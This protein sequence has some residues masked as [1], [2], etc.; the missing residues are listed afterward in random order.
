MIQKRCFLL[1]VLLSLVSFAYAQSQLFGNVSNSSGEKLAGATV[2]VKNKGGY[3]QQYTSTSTTGTFKLVIVDSV[4]RNQPTLDVSLL[5][6]KKYSQVIT[7]GRTSYNVVLEESATLLEEVKV[8]LKGIISIGDTLRYDVSSFATEEDRSIGD[9]IRRLPGVTVS[10]DG[11]IFFNS[12]SISNLFI[13]GDDLMDGRYGLA[14]KAITK[15][16]IKSIDV[17][18]NHQPIKVL[19]DRVPS[20]DVAMNLVL[21]DENS[22]KLSGQADIGYG[23]IDLLDMGLTPILLN[24]KIKTLSSLKYNNLGKDYAVELSQLG[25]PISGGNESLGGL[26]SILSKPGAISLDVP[27]Q[28]YYFNNSGIFNTNNLY[29]FQ[30][31]GWQLKSNIQLHLDKN[32]VD[33]EKKSRMFTKDDVIDYDEHYDLENKPLNFQS[34]ISLTANKSTYFLEN[35]LTYNYSNFKSFNNLLFNS[36]SIGSD[37]Q[38]RRNEFVNNF[39]YIPQLKSKDVL[40]I[41]WTAGY[42][43]SPQSLQ[44][45]TGVNVDFFNKGMPY[46]KLLQNAQIPSYNNQISIGLRKKNASEVWRQNYELE[47]YNEIKDFESVITLLPTLYS[48]LQQYTGDYGNEL[49]WR[50][51]KIQ[52]NPNYSFIKNGWTINLALPIVFRSVKFRQDEYNLNESIN[53]FFLIPNI[54][55]RYKLNAEDEMSLRYNR[56]NTIGNLANVYRG[57]FIKD[58]RSISKSQASLFQRTV[59]SLGLNYNFER[60]IE[61]FFARLSASYQQVNNNATISD[62]F[63]ENLEETVFLGEKNIQKNWLYDFSVGKYIFPLA[64]NLNFKASYMFGQSEQYINQIKVPLEN[65]NLNFTTTM[66]TKP[67]DA[68][69]LDFTAGWGRFWSLSRGNDLGFDMNNDVRNLNLTA[70]SG[71][72]FIKNTLINSKVYYVHTSGQTGSN[73]STFL[74]ANVRYTIKKW[75]TDLNFNFINLLNVK[76]YNQ[77]YVYSNQILHTNYNL[78]G[79]MAVVSTNF[80][81]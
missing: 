29:N 35:K 78:R 47:M 3:I 71:F 24:K 70:E 57:V 52:L 34:S 25:T 5:G 27:K 12:K 11:K 41:R 81:F 54:N 43:N 1:V 65:R 40:D 73:A 56:S 23:P 80:Y 60:S 66:I 20:D 9:V 58:Y 53:D 8:K 19:K 31:K 10:D 67:L 75:K 30:K 38:E 7:L 63:S 42:Y 69:S 55:I 22:L 64:S 44:I 18:K 4:L 49:N 79:R 2:M 16:M 72:S 28:N 15:D 33:Y 17:M 50:Q 51:N 61:M 59:N 68:V 77:Y 21:K 45:D 46:A 32:T 13:H 6:F 48:N 14:T 76:Q 36:Q 37:F 62:S 39:Y 74:D 26:K